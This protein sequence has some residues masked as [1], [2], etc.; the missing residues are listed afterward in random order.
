[1]RPWDVLPP[2][3]TGLQPDTR[4]LGEQTAATELFIPSKT[5]VS[6]QP[7]ISV[8]EELFQEDESFCSAAV[9][10]LVWGFLTS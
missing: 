9:P 2:H 8:D 3:L 1:M 6:P 10:V 7:D 5:F 4:L